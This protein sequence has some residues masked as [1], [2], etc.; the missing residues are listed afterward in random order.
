MVEQEWVPVQVIGVRAADDETVVLLL[1]GV[2]GLLV[3]ILVGRPEAAAIAAARAGLVPSR[4]MTHDLLTAVIGLLGGR[5][6]RVE[7][8]RL[9]QGVFFAELVFSDGGRVD[10]RASDAIALALRAGCP[11]LCSAAVLTEAGVTVQVSASDED[12][13]EFRDFLEQVNA[14]DFEAAPDDGPHEE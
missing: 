3:P 5:L 4:P 13:A 6:T 9:E 1:D 14:D 7:I 2:D 11:V 12:V 8:A 10:S